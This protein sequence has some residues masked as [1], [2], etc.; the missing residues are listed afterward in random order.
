M[1]IFVDSIGCRLNQSEIEKIA[2]DFRARGHELVDSPQQSD[3][4]VINTCAVTG[5]AQADSRHAVRQ[6]A[7]LSKQVI[8]TGCWATL[9]PEQILCLPG[10]IAVVDNYSKEQLVPSFF[11]E[12]GSQVDLGARVPLP[13]SRFRTRAF[14]KAQDGCDQHCTFCVTRVARGRSRSRPVQEIVDDIHLAMQG[15][16]KEAILT[17]VNLG[18]WGK[19]YSPPQALA[20]LI[21]VVL[22]E[23]DV[24]RLRLSSV[25]PWDL[26]EDFFALWQDS[27]LCRHLHLP[28]QSGSDAILK[29][30]GRKTSQEEFWKLVEMTRQ[31]APEMAIS[32]DMIV[33]FPGETEADFEETRE[34]VRSIGFASGHVFAFS[35]RPGT[36]AALMSEKNTSD[37][38]K[39]RSKILRA[40]FAWMQK[41]YQQTFTGSTLSVL[42]ESSQQLKNGY[43]ELSGLSDNYIRIHALSPENRWNQIDWVTTTKMLE[44]GMQAAFS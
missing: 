36:P 6:A 16:T 38:I 28:L 18:S 35:T 24:H 30:M 34:F 29:R 26:G 41:Q 13:G 7:A 11:H 42:W 1:K 27:R 31:V 20:D 9:E 39:R 8:A 23:T 25:E 3:L 40:D 17:G 14:I 4:V 10:L 33:G 43:W 2:A 37:V 21:R 5:K 12:E 15:G 44:N 32:T 22:A 19:E